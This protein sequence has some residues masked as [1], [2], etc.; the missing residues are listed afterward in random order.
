[1]WLLKRSE[2]RRV[3]KEVEISVVGGVWKKKKLRDENWG[4]WEGAKGVEERN[5]REL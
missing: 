2:E 4:S 5:R 1:M 3:G